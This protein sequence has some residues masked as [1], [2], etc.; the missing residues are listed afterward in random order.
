M[1]EERQ[2]TDVNIKMKEMLNLSEKDI[3]MAIIK[4]LQPI[5]YKFS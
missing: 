5:D 1:N 2:L 3:T 4:M